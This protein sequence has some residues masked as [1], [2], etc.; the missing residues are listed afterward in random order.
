MKRLPMKKNFRKD[1]LLA[2]TING[3]K[4]ETFTNEIF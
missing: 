2:I 4:N 3:H 1:T